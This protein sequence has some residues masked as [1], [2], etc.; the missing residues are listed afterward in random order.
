[1]ITSFAIGEYVIPLL[2]PPGWTPYRESVS[3]EGDISD[4]SVISLETLKKRRLASKIENA[5]EEYYALKGSYPFTLEVLVVRELVPKSMIDRAQE[6]GFAY[7]VR[8][9]GKR[10]ALKTD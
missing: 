3:A 4:S 1:M 6:A 5:L 8:P 2:M 7:R 9:D 10:Y